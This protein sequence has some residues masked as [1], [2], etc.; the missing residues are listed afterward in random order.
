MIVRN[1]GLSILAAAAALSFGGSMAF[2]QGV[3]VRDPAAVVVVPE[4]GG[5]THVQVPPGTPTPQGMMQDTPDQIQRGRRAESEAAA[6]RLG[7]EDTVATVR[8]AEQA[9]RA[10]NLSLAN[11]LA[12]R[13]ETRLLTGS[14]IAGAER[15]PATG[16][17][18][19]K[20]QEGRAALAR[21]DQAQAAMLFAEAAG[22]L[23][24]AR[25]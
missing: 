6:D 22:L 5:P 18:I 14:T 23:G 24:A 16:G 7:A 3:A 9:A 19:G 20:L 21:R 12:E 4:R 13:V 1:K 11:E 10:G 15:M 8:Q 17:V 25:R 2:A